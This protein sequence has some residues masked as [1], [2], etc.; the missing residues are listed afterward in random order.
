MPTNQHFFVPEV[1]QTSEMDC[2]PASLKALLEGFGISASYG[3]LRE[4]CQTEVDGTSIDVI[5]QIAVQLGLDAEQI[6]IPADHL[7]LPE[8]NALPALVVVR[9]PNGL[10]HFIIIWSQ[11]GRFVQVMDPGIGRRWVEEKRLLAELYIHRFPVPAQS[12]RDWAGT[13]GFLAPLRRRLGELQLTDARI[14]ELIAQAVA[15]PGWRGLA[16]LDAA[17][18]MVA[19]IV[20]ANGLERGEIATQ[21]LTR[22]FEEARLGA[23]SPDAPV[24]A[25]YWFAEPLPR[26]PTFVDTD[27]AGERRFGESSLLLRGAVLVHV[28][29]E[30]LKPPEVLVEKKLPPELAAALQE[31]PLHPEKELWRA[32]RQDG[33]F[34]LS[35]L[36]IALFMAA[37]GVTIEALLLQ[38]VMKLGLSLPESGSR[39]IAIAILFA[40][41][42][43]LF[44]LEL[45]LT[46]I[47]QRIG[48]RLETRLRILLL[49]KIPRLSDRYFHSRL[50]SD[51]TMRAHGLRS[52]RTLPTLA[53]SVLRLGFQLVLT[54]LGVII[55]DPVSAPW[56]MAFTVVFGVVAYFSSIVQRERE[57]RLFT[58]DGALSRFYLD[59]L[60]GLVPA[61][62]HGAER[63][64]RREH[65]TRLTEW[66]RSSFETWRMIVALQG[67][68]ALLY[69]AFSVIILLN[70]VMSGGQTSNI[71]LLFYWTLNL[72]VLAQSLFALLEQ[73]PIARNHTLR[74]LE[75]LG[76]PDETRFQD[77]GFK[78]SSSASSNLKPETLNHLGV[79]IELQNVQVQ[80]GGHTILSD[81]NLQIKPGEHVAIVGPSGAGKSTLVGILLGWHKPAEG[82]CLIDDAPL[83]GGRLRALRRDTAWVDPAVQ[84]WNRSLIA[85]LQYGNPD[86]DNSVGNTLEEADLYGIL[87]RLPDGMQTALGE[88]G[89]L[90]SGGEGQRVRLGRALNKPDVRLAILDE[91]FRGLDRAKRSALLAQARAHWRGATMFCITHDVAETQAFERVLVIENGRIVED[92]APA[93]LAAQPASRYRAMLDAEEAVRRGLWESADWRRLWIEEGEL[94]ESA[95]ARGKV[96]AE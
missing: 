38:G 26:E 31:P 88:S 92:A 51:M 36:I 3:R 60:L 2:G 81:I 42:L 84:V 28:R 12:F 15:D 43:F 46:A 72:P 65:E 59:A 25:P 13:E 77:S 68:S 27:A 50:T 71:L 21:V 23:T 83:D 64:M 73:Y 9:L 48:R 91:P 17:T 32:V 74:L 94:R 14:A 76:A 7:L 90:V 70:F 6:M 11:H 33:L 66:T 41:V 78:V 4:A 96:A 40:L 53:V 37:L 87:E 61:R 86:G 18:R 44:A 67:V 45:P 63:S 30:I 19:S 80:A 49:E 10:T 95:E 5:E 52:L 55:L 39:M 82:R 20:R 79:T 56:A 85:N 34:A 1:V 29:G 75:P 35:V 47:E 93:V 24:P 89:G 54:A 57:M 62:M 22:F 69:A 8:A 58:H 16:A